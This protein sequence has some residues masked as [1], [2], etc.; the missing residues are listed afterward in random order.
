MSVARLFAGAAATSSNSASLIIFCC[1]MGEVPLLFSFPA[2]DRFRGFFFTGNMVCRHLT[3]FLR[4]R[5]INEVFYF[6]VCAL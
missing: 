1:L 2:G 4:K 5:S 3:G 6:F